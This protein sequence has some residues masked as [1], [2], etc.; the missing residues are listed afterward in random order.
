VSVREGTVGDETRRIRATSDRLDL[1]LDADLAGD[2][3]AGAFVEALQQR[4][5]DLTEDLD[6]IS[7]SNSQWGPSASRLRNRVETELERNLCT[8]ELARLGVPVGVRS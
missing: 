3:L 8:V 2:A 7:R 1:G 5:A 6:A 4:Y